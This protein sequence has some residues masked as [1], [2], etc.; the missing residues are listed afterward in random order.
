MTDQG[1]VVDS[2]GWER[3]AVS[4]EVWQDLS[5]KVILL[6]ETWMIRWRYTSKG[7][8]EGFQTETTAST[9]ILCTKKGVLVS[10]MSDAEENA[11][12]R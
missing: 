1:N 8:E 11:G 12:G 2:N 4:Q 7:L 5:E 9:N 3:D 10:D 6:S